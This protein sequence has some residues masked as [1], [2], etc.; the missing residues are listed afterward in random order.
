MA[1]Q[2]VIPGFRIFLVVG[3]E[4][5]QLFHRIDRTDDRAVAEFVLALVRQGYG[6][7]QALPSDCVST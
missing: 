2:E 1:H 6:S 3:L 4:G 7:G 5:G